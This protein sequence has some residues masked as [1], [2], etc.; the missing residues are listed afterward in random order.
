MSTY[1]GVDGTPAPSQLDQKRKQ[2]MQS[3]L[4][5]RPG[6]QRLLAQAGVSGRGGF[7]RG[8]TANDS[9][10]A[11]IPG[12]SFNPFL[13]QL[14]RGASGLAQPTQSLRQNINAPGSGLPAS[15][16]LI[17]SDNTPISPGDAGV[18]APAPAIAPADLG[19]PASASAAPDLS[20]QSTLD[21]WFQPTQGIYR[22]LFGVG[23]APPPAT[24]PLPYLGRPGR[25]S[26]TLI[27]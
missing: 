9:P 19:A 6:Q 25:F 7:T 27:G 11:A 21:Q 5:G 13:A 20:Q 10:N 24:T 26:G 15:G 4:S 1:F 16:G 12:L 23:D 8:Y 22:Q 18:G 3:L 17:A 14:Q 2:L